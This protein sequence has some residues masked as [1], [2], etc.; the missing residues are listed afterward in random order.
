MKRVT[1]IM[2][3]DIVIILVMSVPMLMFAVYPGLKLGDYFEEKHNVEEK[4]KRIVII[5]T[6]VVFAVTLSSLLHFL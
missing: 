1:K 4:Q 5:A 6:T 2:F 3:Q